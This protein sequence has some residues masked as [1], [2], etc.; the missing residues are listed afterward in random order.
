M[1]KWTN[2]ILFVQQTWE[3]FKNNPPVQ[4][5]QNA[6]EMIDSINESRQAM[7]EFI[8]GVKSISPLSDF[9]TTGKI[10]KAYLDFFISM[11]G[12]FE[13]THTYSLNILRETE[14][15]ENKGNIII[16]KLHKNRILLKTDLIRSKKPIP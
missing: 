14:K 3:S 16:N 9:S 1:L 8:K 5:S 12:V 7:T 13:K 2:K 15:L 6:R 11:D 10:F 4:S